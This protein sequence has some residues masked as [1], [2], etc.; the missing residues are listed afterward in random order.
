[1][2]SSVFSSAIAT[3]AAILPEL[4]SKSPQR[5]FLFRFS[6]TALEMSASLLKFGT[7]VIPNTI[8][9]ESSTVLRSLLS[10]V[11]CWLLL[12]T[13]LL[14]RWNKAEI[15]E[16]A[17]FRK[18]ILAGVSGFSAQFIKDEINNSFVFNP[19]DLHPAVDK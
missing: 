19:C 6:L 1:M 9:P 15:F 2:L 17:T 8:I 16:L 7:L 12:V 18:P 14:N 3:V 11:E 4:K 5:T 10:K 13:M